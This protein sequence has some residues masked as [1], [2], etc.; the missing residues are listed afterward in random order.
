MTQRNLP[1]TCYTLPL[2]AYLPFD[3]FLEDILLTSICSHTGLEMEEGE[4]KAA[5]ISIPNVSKLSKIF[6]LVG[7]VLNY[8]LANFPFF[9][10][11][12]GQYYDYFSKDMN[13]IESNQI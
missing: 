4:G 7:Q 6:Y 9:S 13:I 2:G 12:L 3:Y 11:I 10:K 5:A 8:F 1:H